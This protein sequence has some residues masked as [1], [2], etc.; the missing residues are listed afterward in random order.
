MDNLHEPAGGNRALDIR[1]HDGRAVVASL[2]GLDLAGV[3]GP[4]RT[5]GSFVLNTDSGRF[6]GADWECADLAGEAGSGFSLRQRVSGGELVL[7][8]AWAV[9]A[10][11]GVG[12]RNDVRANAG[13]EPA[14]VRRC[15]ARVSLP[16]GRYEVYFQQSR[17]CNENQGAWQALRAGELALRCVSGRSAQG[18]TPYACVRSVETGRGLVFHVLPRGN[19]VIRLIS[20]AL[21]G[22]SLPGVVVELGL[23]DE[24]LR[25]ALQ[26]GESLALPELLFQELPGGEPH[27]AAPALHR[28]LLAAFFKSQ[29]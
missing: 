15:L 13:R 12:S 26:P 27:L 23:S 3:E 25:L 8:S 21:A 4:A 2:C 10:A 24:N 29:A 5:Q 16:A 14:I 18:G 9:D 28:H 22:D 11:T 17:W 19:W 6:E 7:R 1:V 20:A